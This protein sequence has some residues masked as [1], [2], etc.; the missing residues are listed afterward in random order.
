MSRE[1]GQPTDG[2]CHPAPGGQAD[3]KE[4]QPPAPG[5]IMGEGSQIL[6]ICEHEEKI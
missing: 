5:N 4:G 3:R 6:S 1:D 2:G